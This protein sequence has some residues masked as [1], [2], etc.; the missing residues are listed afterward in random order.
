MGRYISTGIIY[1]YGFAKSSIPGI[2][3]PEIKQQFIEHLFPEIYDFQEDEKY[4]YL[5]LSSNLT[6]S[7]LISA[8]DSYYS[9]IGLSKQEREEFER[10][11]Q[12]LAGKTIDQA[13]EE[14]EEKP[15]YLYQ[16]DELGY[17]YAYYAIPLVINGKRKLYPV[18]IWSIMIHQSS[19]KTITE[20]DLLSYDFFTDLL[21]Y[22]MKPVKLADAMLIYLSA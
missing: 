17:S 3:S 6:V 1:T 8:M 18:H 5:S 2:D 4:L 16:A 21:R 14:A 22:R 15:S 19:A 9:L 12:L 7:D 10:V 20:D 11:K 13:Y